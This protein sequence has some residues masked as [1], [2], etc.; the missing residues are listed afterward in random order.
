M[1]EKDLNPANDKIF[2][3]TLALF[4]L[5]WFGLVFINVFRFNVTHI[6]ITVF[7]AVMLAFNLY[8]YYRC[9]KVQSENVK[10]LMYQYGTDVTAQFMKGAIVAK[11]F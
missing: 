2:W 8:S 3:W 7:C 10:K 1:N 4:T 5:I 9:S 11:F 6:S